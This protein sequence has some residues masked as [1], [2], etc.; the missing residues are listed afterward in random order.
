MLAD[1]LEHIL[2]GGGQQL[3]MPSS[4][5]QDP[6]DWSLGL[7]HVSAGLESY[8]SAGNGMT[9]KEAFMKNCPNL[10]ADRNLVKALAVYASRFRNKNQDHI[11]FFGGNLIGVY[12]IKFTIADRNEWFDTILDTDE[13]DLTND[14]HG[15]MFVN[16]KFHVTGDLFN[17]SMPVLLHLLHHS[18]H[19]SSA[20]IEQ[21]KMDVVRIFHY[22]N[23]SSILS[24]DYP[25]PANKSVAME[26]YRQLSK[27]FDLKQ[28]GSWQA[29][30]DARAK[31]II[32]QGTGIHYETYV[33]MTDDKAVI[34]M[35][36]D[37]Q[38]RLRDVI[39]SINNVFHTVKTKEA[40]ITEGSSSVELDGVKHIRDVERVV[41]MYLRYVQ[42]IV[43][44]ESDWYRPELASI[45]IKSNPTIP[46]QPL[47]TALRY[48]SSNY[49][50]D[51]SGMIDNLLKETIQHL[52]EYISSKNLKLGDVPDVVSKMKGAYRSSR[53]SNESLL[54]M[55]DIGDEIVSIATGIRTPATIATVRV[56]LFL[57]IILRA[58]SMKH[59]TS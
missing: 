6:I 15:T 57:Y 1:D 17:L 38:D 39:N 19:L 29:L 47:E 48:I 44:V 43:G 46:P 13:V 45:I 52:F 16:P 55:R 40:M 20:E 22:K 25:Y 54:K 11:S 49:R 4:L 41:S 59:Y 35:V 3:T 50:Y 33:R 5:I 42:N 9:I 37:V 23:L 56:G 7:T 21:G 30:I 26:T 24:H 8:A 36:G 51:K 34:Y 2:S 12:P 10:V 27:K 32:T 31:S 53:T 28:Y 14:V 18:K 58:L